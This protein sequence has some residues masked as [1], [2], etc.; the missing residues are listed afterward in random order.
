[1]NIVKQIILVEAFSRRNAEASVCRH[2]ERR[3]KGEWDWLISQSADFLFYPKVLVD[4]VKKS[5]P[6]IQLYRESKQS[7]YD[8]D[9][10]LD[11][12]EDVT[13]LIWLSKCNRYF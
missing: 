1:M 5:M 11:D 8:E 10:D 12:S 9:E 7:D 13:Q 2:K 4:L 6:E 3:Q